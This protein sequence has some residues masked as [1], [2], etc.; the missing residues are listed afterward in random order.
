MK[1]ITLPAGKAAQ[2]EFLSSLGVYINH[3]DG[4]Q[5]FKRGIVK[6]D[7]DGNLSGIE[8]DVSKFSTFVSVR[9]INTARKAISVKFSGKITVGGIL[10]LKY[11]YKDAENDKESGTKIQ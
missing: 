2:E 11:T 5:E 3:S 7:N 9:I 1:D 10:T 6:Y 8:I 4:E